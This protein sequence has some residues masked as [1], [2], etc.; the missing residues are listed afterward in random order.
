[1]ATFD[2]IRPT[3]SGASLLGLLSAPLNGLVSRVLDWNDARVTRNA[4][5][6]LTDREL[7]D[8]GLARGDIDSVANGTY[9]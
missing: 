2:T 3:A 1:M 9:R 7:S 6:E 8:I 5:L 4:L